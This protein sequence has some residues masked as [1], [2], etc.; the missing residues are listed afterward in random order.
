MTDLGRVLSGAEFNARVLPRVGKLYKLLFADFTHRKFPYRIG[1]NQLLEPFNPSGRCCA[2]GLYFTHL[3]AIHHWMA[4]RQQDKSLL[5]L[6]PLIAEVS[7]R[8]TARVY[9]ESYSQFKC[10]ELLLFNLQS[11]DAFVLKCGDARIIDVYVLYG[12]KVS[13]ELLRLAATVNPSHV[14][15]LIRP[16]ASEIERYRAYYLNNFGITRTITFTR[17][18]R[19]SLLRRPRRR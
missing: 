11:L 19:M 3:N 16:T 5:E 6:L 4:A 2:G 18:S 8:D 13:D 14:S 12:Q 10:D 9:Y 17:P 1:L 7:I 15:Q